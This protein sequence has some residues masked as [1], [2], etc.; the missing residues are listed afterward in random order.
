[1]G[2][3]P[4]G[5]K[6]CPAQERFWY[7][8]GGP[9]PSPLSTAPVYTLPYTLS[10]PLLHSAILSHTSALYLPLQSYLHPRCHHPGCDM[11]GEATNKPDLGKGTP[12]TR[13]AWGRVRQTGMQVFPG[14]APQK[15]QGARHTVNPAVQACHLGTADVGRAGPTVAE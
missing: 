2:P 3:G 14:G 9:H 1:M 6:P 5:L 12:R 4:A 11:P 7:P 13:A 10:T 15:A 8:A